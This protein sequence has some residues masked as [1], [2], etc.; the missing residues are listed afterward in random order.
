MADL[1]KILSVNNKETDQ[2]LQSIDKGMQ[3]LIKLTKQG[4]KD[5]Q[6]RFD[7]S[8]QDR[9]RRE[10]KAPA[11]AI[12]TEKK[13]VE[14]KKK[15]KP[16]RKITDLFNGAKIGG[17]IVSAIAS[18]LPGALKAALLGLKIALPAAAV[19]AAAI[20][21]T[22][23]VRSGAEKYD[24]FMGGVGSTKDGDKFIMTDIAALKAKQAAFERK[25]M[26][27][28]GRSTIDDAGMER[29]GKFDKVSLAMKAAKKAN[30]DIYRAKQLNKED[31]AMVDGG[32]LTIKDRQAKE[33][34][35]KK[36]QKEIEKLE[37]DKLYAQKQTT[38][39][40]HELQTT[41]QDLYRVQVKAG[42]RALSQVPE[43]L[44]KELE[45]LNL[46]PDLLDQ[47][48]SSYG[49]AEQVGHELYGL[50]V[51]Q[52][53]TG[54]PITVPGSGSGDKIP[55]MLKP[56]NF[57]LN[58][59]ASNFLRRQEGGSV[60]ALLEPGELVYPKTS[61]QLDLLNKDIPRFQN[62][63]QVSHQ[64][65]G[66]GYQPGNAKDQSGRPIV[67]S[68]G[69]SDAFSRMMKDGG[70]QGSDVASSQR[71]P[72]KNAAVGG[73][74]NSAHLGGNAIDIHGAS[75]SW[76]I[77]NSEKYGWKR[78]NYMAD[79]W[80]WDYTG[81]N[82]SV[83]GVNEGND[84]K[85]ENKN[86]LETG[87]E[88]V[89]DAVGGADM[90]AGIGGA[91]GAMAL[92]S[93]GVNLFGGASPVAIGAIMGPAL[94]GTITELVGSLFGSGGSGGKNDGESSGNAGGGANGV[95]SKNAKALLNA[96]ADAE[97]TSGYANQGYNT[98]F[99]GKQFTG[100]N[101]PREVINSGGYGSDAAGRYQFL[102]TTWD[103]YSGGKNMSPNNQDIVAMD[104]VRKKRGVNLSDGLSLAE[105][106]KLG[107]EWASIE[108]GPDGVKGG[109]YSGQAK[110]S[111]EKFM[112]MYKGY[113][114]AL[115]LQ[116]GGS[117]PTLL[118]P[119]EMVF[120]QTTGNLKQL[121]SAVP[122]FQNGGSVMDPDNAM[123]G[124]PQV[125]VVQAPAPHSGNS[126]QSANNVQTPTA[127]ALSDGPSMASISDIINRVSWS[128]VF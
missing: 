13:K 92:Q 37:N 40:Y 53:Q 52:K 125:V 84:D 32:K 59:T 106:Y 110:F 5:E 48:F 124:S 98:Q 126:G 109:S 86:V 41:Q 11:A 71:S 95:S 119:G 108:G 14:E 83:K 23:A 61:P 81:K 115:Q 117:V 33:R 101:H 27:Q 111:A 88:K 36:R 75:K 34:N 51:Q 67:L 21:G 49:S 118:E 47:T 116:Q 35:I 68:K 105:T 97:G 24:K 70:V 65:T 7:K 55:M 120:P 25:M 80:H 22:K 63:G 50:P 29:L 20:G 78:N 66:S 94:L 102:S 74:P 96:I 44:R 100:T 93:M 114:G 6:K 38:K 39:L 4:Q 18:A 103:E 58:R 62:G 56:G 112:S 76:M 9:K 90:L 60:P 17:Q 10:R 46:A 2:K 26:E 73:V 122:R 28:Q 64:D 12:R 16:E 1:S 57:V 31:Q 82:S 42:R 19:A 128:N 45:A 79:S 87:V 89:L 104:L 54:G 107:Q 72:Q 3:T 127:P 99:T 123:G 85:S 77:S 121:N 30:D 15:A 69:A 113:G 91:A 43:K 8:E